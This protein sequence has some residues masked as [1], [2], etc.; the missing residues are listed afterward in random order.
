MWE[1][2]EQVFLKKELSLNNFLIS[3]RIT[4]SHWCELSL[5][6]IEY[7]SAEQMNPEL[8]FEKPHLIRKLKF[9]IS[10]SLAVIFFHSTC[11]PIFGSF[12]IFK[13]IFF[14][15]L[16]TISFLNRLI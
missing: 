10:N 5:I 4:Q 16:K 11:Y 12:T 14:E 7:K 2:K 8:I 3:V 6:N 15:N 13:S 1:T 9:R